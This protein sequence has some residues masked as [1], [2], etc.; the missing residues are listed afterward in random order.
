MV[1]RLPGSNPFT[2]SRTLA[3]IAGLLVVAAVVV[4]LILVVGGGGSSSSRTPN[5]SFHP[6]T[7][8]ALPAVN[9][10]RDNLQTI[11]TEGSAII[12]DPAGEIAQLHALGVNR[13][14]VSFTW[15]SIAPKGT[16]FKKP[17]FDATDPNA[18]PAAN[19]APY[20][21]ITRDLA[22]DHMTLDLVL[23]PPPPQW[24]AG[25]GIPQ[26]GNPHP[27]WK[28]SAHDF[29]Q[30]VEAVGKRYSGTF[31]PKGQS[32]PLPRENFWSLWNEPNIGVM[33]A[34]QSV[35]GPTIESSP[36]QYRHLADAA[37]TAL[38]RTGHGSDTI[39]ADEIAPAGGTIAGAPGNFNAMAPLRFLRV[40][41]CVDP[42]FQF[43]SGKAATERGCPAKMNTKQFAA[44]N[45]VLFHATAVGAHFYS[46]GLAPNAVTPDEPDYAELGEVSNLFTTLDHLQ[47]IYG[48]H[49]KFDVYDTE[50]GYQT[51]PPDTQS[52][53][54][55]PKQAAKWL[56]WSEYIHWHYPRILSYDQ[57]LMEDPQPV[58][59]K[60]QYKS[61][62]TGI[63]TYKGKRKPGWYAFRM[64]VW[65]PKTTTSATGTLEV[66]GTARP[67]K[68]V[69]MAQRSPVQIQFK[70]KSGGAWKTVATESTRT[71]FGYFDVH[72][73]F[74]ASGLV[75]LRWSPPHGAAMVSRTTPITVG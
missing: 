46:Q 3:A 52:G 66:W 32:T 2:S 61:F 43:Y 27:Y 10:H 38:H 69:P 30:F 62:A 36:T 33:L 53:T 70:P 54:V 44:A 67:A 73:K 1:L 4:V 56:N 31:T 25:K 35:N 65:L 71:S 14:R 47:Q 40:L 60:R 39:L 48:S 15:G 42:K 20:D 17:R 72:Q 6:K 34:P 58:P 68:F 18:Y 37:W 29:E 74:P 7:A 55:S 8:G 16:S 21:A 5:L 45:P 23:A 51:T 13:V 12:Q 64:P 63:V 59:G 49:K 11:F 57:Y 75:R 19:W 9:P 26:D 24:A 22:A 41:Y 28:P 50:F